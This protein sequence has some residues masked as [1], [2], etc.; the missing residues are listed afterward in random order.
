MWWRA[1][2]LCG[3]VLARGQSAFTNFC[4]AIIGYMDA[5]FEVLS[6]LRRGKLLHESPSIS[7]ISTWCA[8]PESG[9]WRVEHPSTHT[10]SGHHGVMVLKTTSQHST[11]RGH[12]RQPSLRIPGLA[13][14]GCLVVT[15]PRR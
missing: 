8:G 1:M 5:N 7:W 14:L 6:E 15:G 12:T 2:R 3:E 11:V 10:L 13:I 4:S 9:L